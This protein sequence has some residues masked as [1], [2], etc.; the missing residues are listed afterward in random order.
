MAPSLRHKEH[1]NGDANDGDDDQEDDEDDH[2]GAAKALT[3]PWRLAEN[4][5]R[6]AKRSDGGAASNMPPSCHE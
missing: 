1:S 5:S 6:V 3:L 2:A 4:A